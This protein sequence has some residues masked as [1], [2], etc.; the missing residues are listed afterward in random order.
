MILRD[1][2][3]SEKSCAINDYS[4]MIILVVLIILMIVMRF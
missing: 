4:E 3:C 2:F 1:G